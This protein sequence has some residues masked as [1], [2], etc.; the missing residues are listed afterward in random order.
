M[1]F[2]SYTFKGLI[3]LIDSAVVVA[4]VLMIYITY[5]DTHQ[6]VYIDKIKNRYRK[7]LLTLIRRQ[8]E[9]YDFSLGEEGIRAVVEFDDKAGLLVLEEPVFH[10]RFAP[11]YMFLFSRIS[12][13]P[14]TVTHYDVLMGL[15][16]L[17]VL[18]S[19]VFYGYNFL[20]M[21]GCD[22]EACESIIMA[23]IGALL[24]FITV[25]LMY[26]LIQSH[27]QRCKFGAFKEECE[28]MELAYNVSSR[29]LRFNNDADVA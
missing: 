24:I 20:G 13:Y 5:V 11:K 10:K 25:F 7:N 12:R 8:I 27:I 1:L 2:F 4:S 26:Y 16:G 17:I 6:R 18:L 22:I 9:S 21:G 15:L 28:S 23:C 14:L 3:E 29:Q 19:L